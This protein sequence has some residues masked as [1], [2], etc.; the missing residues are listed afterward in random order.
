MVA[1]KNVCSTPGG[2]NNLHISWKAR[3]CDVAEASSLMY[4]LDDLAN[5]EKQTLM[6]FFFTDVQFG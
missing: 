5:G 3:I 4:S 6:S 2:W 1:E